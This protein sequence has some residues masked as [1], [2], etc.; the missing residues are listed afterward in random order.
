VDNLKERI[1]A[2]EQEQPATEKQG[3]SQTDK[4]NA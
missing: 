2:F 1:Q 4:G 3:G